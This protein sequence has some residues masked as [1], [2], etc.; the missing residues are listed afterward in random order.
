MR[1]PARPGFAPDP[2][3]WQPVPPGLGPLLSRLGIGSDHLALCVFSSNGEP[4]YLRLDG[5]PQP[6]FIKLV[7]GGE[8]AK[9]KETFALALNLAGLGVPTPS[10]VWHK[11]TETGVTAFAYEWVDGHHPSGRDLDFH[12]MGQAIA[13]L[14]HALSKL[15]AKAE[16]SER[17]VKW[18]DALNRAVETS[19]VFS[20]GSLSRW[21]VLASRCLSAFTSST[22]AILSSG[23]PIHGDLNPG[24]MLVSNGD[25]VFL[26][27]EEASHSAL[28]R[29]L[30]LAKIAERLILPQIEAFGVDWAEESLRT[31]LAG[32]RNAGMQLP[33]GEGLT[34]S[35][36]LLWHTG[37][38]VA[39][40]ATQSFAT[41]VVEAEMRKFS[42]LTGLI[43]RHRTMLDTAASP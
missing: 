28:W 40:L 2:L 20:A 3:D 21:D 33:D 25:V 34:F 32:Y 15:P 12:A 22:Q 7:S 23:T 14:H 38:A 30:D 11:T 13:M 42:Y 10:P 35:D 41:G 36:A 9:E 37:L 29:G 18:V 39:I 26:D 17:T 8:L 43:D 27:L 31:L 1:P 19:N 4:A 5:P 16:I 6:L 24:N